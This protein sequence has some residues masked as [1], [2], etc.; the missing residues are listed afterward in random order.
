MEVLGIYISKERFEYVVIEKN[1]LKSIPMEELN[2]VIVI[3]ML[4]YLR[5]RW[6]FTENHNSYWPVNITEL[7]IIQ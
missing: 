6:K 3:K 4:S 1:P 7:T 2:L 5:S